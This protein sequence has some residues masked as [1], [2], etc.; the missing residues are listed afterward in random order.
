MLP[1]VSASWSTQGE[2]TVRVEVRGR[3]WR[4]ARGQNRIKL[5]L[6]R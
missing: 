2:V 4:Y 6:R 5:G 3:C 1:Y